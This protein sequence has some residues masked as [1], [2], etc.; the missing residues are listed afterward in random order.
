MLKGFLLSIVCLACGVSPIE[1]SA[2]LVPK[3]STAKC[4]GHFED[5]SITSITCGYSEKGCTYGSEVFVTGQVYVSGDIPRP[6]EVKMSRT[7]P[8]FYAIGTNIYNGEIEDICYDTI[9]PGTDDAEY[10][11]PNQGQYNFHFKYNNFGT[12]QK[13]YAGWHGYSMGMIVHFKH[14]SGGNDYATC[15]INV[16]AEAADDEDYSYVTDASFVSVAVVGFAGLL[17]GLFVR[18]RKEKLESSQQ[19][20]IDDGRTKEL[21]TNFELIQ[22]SSSSVVV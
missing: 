7:F 9:A 2:I 12:R 20:N 14:E 10:S 13:W 22:D 17:A 4:E 11:C 21:N 6:M 19:Q 1:G 15:T 8:S 16:K 5:V 18:R 3:L